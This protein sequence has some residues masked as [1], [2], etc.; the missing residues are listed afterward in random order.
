[1][2]CLNAPL[3]CS[4]GGF[5]AKAKN[6]PSSCSSLANLARDRQLD[7]TKVRSLLLLKCLDSDC[8]VSRDVRQEI[9]ETLLL[10][11]EEIERG[12]LGRD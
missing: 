6:N 5:G 2:S 10:P 11:M 7:P 1:M 3:P 12:K 9:E 4:G 8:Y